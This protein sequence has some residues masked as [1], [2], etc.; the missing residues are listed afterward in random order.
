MNVQSLKVAT[1]SP[2]TP[3]A[4]PLVATLPVNSQFS[5]VGCPLMKQMAPPKPLT[6]PGAAWLLVKMQFRIVGEPPRL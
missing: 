5:T 4:P 2:K 6:S 3:T 1:A